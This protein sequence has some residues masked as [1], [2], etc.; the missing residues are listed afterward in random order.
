MTP[1]LDIYGSEH[2][3]VRIGRLASSLLPEGAR[4]RAHAAT[5]NAIYFATEEEDLVWLTT[6]DAVMH[7]RGIQIAGALPEAAPGTPYSVVNRRLLLGAELAFD[8][9]DAARWDVPQPLPGSFPPL[10][11]LRDSLPAAF[12]ALSELPLPK[13]LGILFP[14]I[15]KLAGIPV[16]SYTALHPSLTVHHAWPIIREVVG[17]ILWGNLRGAVERAGDL[18]GLGEG[19]TPSGDDFVGGFLFSLATL[20][21]TRSLPRGHLEPATVGALLQK[22]RSRTHLISYVIL[23]DHALGHGCDAL[24]DLTYGL[25]GGQSLDNIHAQAARLVGL[26]H[27]TGWDILTGVVVGLLAA[28]RAGG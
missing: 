8:M 21:G 4:G 16:V 10:S 27:S 12:A 23:K 2:V 20:M 22:S 26:G 5:S 3:V 1:G 19:M 6:R 24:Q 25:L 17:S 13:G 28:L 18:I 7:R 15:M 14:E 9:S 11:A